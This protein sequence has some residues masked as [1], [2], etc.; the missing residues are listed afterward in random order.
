[1]SSS[2]APNTTQAAPRPGAVARTI[3]AFFAGL[4]FGEGLALGGMTDPAIVLGFL[5]VAGAW[6]P[7]LLGVLGGAVV[8]A[9][10]GFQLV[11]LNRRPLLA[12]RFDAP[13][14]WRI[15]APLLAGAALFGI[16][17]GLVGY[18]PGPALAA[19]PAALPGTALFVL[20]MLAGLGAVRLWRARQTPTVTMRPVGS[21]PV[22][23]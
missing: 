18:C 13:T 6:N 19:L 12:E 4:L 20:A 1:M 9:F 14:R 11:S 16:G 21:P 8:V 2:A 17:W 7:A 3:V 10:A 22:G 5:D 15:D 23:L